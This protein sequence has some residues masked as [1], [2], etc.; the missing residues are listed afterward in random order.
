MLYFIKTLDKYFDVI[1][2]RFCQYSS[3][4][5]PGSPGQVDI[6][7][8]QSTQATITL[9]LDELLLGMSYFMTLCKQPLVIQIDLDEGDFKSFEVSKKTKLSLRFKY[10]SI[11]C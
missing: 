4:V 7:D 9:T 2:R 5:V 11:F 3:S 10:S 1:H 6:T 8:I